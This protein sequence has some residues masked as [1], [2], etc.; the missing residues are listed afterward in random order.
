[1]E[2]LVIQVIVQ[3]MVSLLK[4]FFF[5]E[6]NHYGT[7]V[8]WIYSDIGSLVGPSESQSSFG[9]DIIF[10]FIRMPFLKL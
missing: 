9:Q 2:L 1:M 10:R 7:R 4:V 8:S 6:Y 3:L 5:N